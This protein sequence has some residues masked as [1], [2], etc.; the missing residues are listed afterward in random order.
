M[1]IASDDTHHI[2]AC[3]YANIYTD[4]QCCESTIRILQNALLQT[5]INSPHFSSLTTSL[6]KT[7]AQLQEL[8]NKLS[9]IETDTK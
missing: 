5:P 3:A 1:S 7:K 6:N 2:D 9:S 8:K 4:I